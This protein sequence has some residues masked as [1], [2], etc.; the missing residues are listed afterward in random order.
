MTTFSTQNRDFSCFLVTKH[1]W[2]GKY[3]RVFSIGTHAITTYNPQTLEVTNQFL[4]DDFV[5]I[6]PTQRQPNADP[7]QGDEFVIVYRKK[8]KSDNMRFSS[9]FTQEILSQAL[10]FQSQFSE[11]PAANTRYS[12]VKYG[13][14]TEKQPCILEVGPDGLHQLDKT[15]LMLKVYRYNHIKHVYRLSDL[16]G[17]FV[18]E[19]GEQLRRHLFSNDD[20]N[21]LIQE[22]RANASECVGVYIPLAKDP[23]SFEDFV[24]TRLGL[25]SKDEQLTSYTEFKVQKYTPRSEKMP[26]RRLLCLSESCIIERDPATY[27]VICARPLK[28]IICLVREL[29]DPQKF[30]I[31]YENGD[32]RTYTSNERDLILASLIDGSRGSGNYNIFVASRRY[33]RN[34]RLM[35]FKQLLDEEGEAQLMKQIINVTPGLKRSD[36]IRRFNA[37]VPYN[38]LTYSTVSES[39]F[40]DSNKNRMIVN[41]LETVL[42]ETYAID[43]PESIQKTEAQLACLHRLF[44]SKSGF[45][46]FTAVNGVREKLGALV[47]GVLKRKHE[48]IDHATVEMLCSLMQ[49]MHANYELRLEQLNKQSLLSSKPFVEHLLDLIVEHVTRGTGALVIASMLD[50]LTYTV[51]YP[52]SET[53]GGD[54]F[55]VVIELVAERG[56][57]FYRLFHNPSMTIVKGAGMVMRAIIEESGREISKLMQT[58]S[59][60]E[61][62]FLKHLEMALLASGKDLRVLTNKQL[63]G[64]LISLWIA[65]NS[66]A[67][68]LLRRCIPRGLLDNLE[69]T[70][71]PPNLEKDLLLTRNNLEIATQETKSSALQ[72]QLKSMQYTV[73]AKLETFFQHWNLGQTMTKR[74][75]EKNQKPVVLRKR[76]RQVKTSANWKMFAY[77]FAQDHAK[78][79]LIWNEKTR[80]EFRQAIENEMRLLQQELEF[81]QKGDTLVSWNHTEF[82]IAYPSLQDEIKIGDYYLRFLLNEDSEAATPIHDPQ[83]F[84]NSVY[85]RFLLFTPIDMKCLCLKAMGIAYERHFMTIGAFVDSKYIVQML[86][87]CTNVA[88]RDHLL[89][90][91]NKL[92]LDKNN[93]RELITAGLLPILVDLAMLGHLHVNRP[94]LPTQQNVIEAGSTFTGS[95]SKEWHYTDKAGQRQGPLSFQEMKDLYKEGKIFEKTEIW[96]EGLD[97]WMNL[98]AVA[99]FRWTICCKTPANTNQPAG[100]YNLTQLTVLVLDTLIQ[101]C[102]F[103]PS[104][105][106][107]GA[108]IRPMP[109]V[110]KFLSDPV[111]LYQV[112]QLLLTYD[113]DVVRRVATLVL[114][115]M[116]DNP[117][118]S[119]LYLS[120]LYFFILMYNGSD[121]LPVAR[122]L[123]YTHLKQAFR[124]TLAKSEI[125]SCSV[126]SPILPEA[127]IYYLEQY[128]PEKYAEVFLGEFETPEIIWNTEMRRHMFEQIAKHVA[129]FSSRL[130]SNTKALYKY[131]PIPPI[132]YPQLEQELFCHYYYL[133]HLC[134]EI[135]FPNWEIRDPVVFLRCCLAAWHEELERKPPTMSIEKACETLGLDST[136]ESWQDGAAVRRAYY[137]LASQYHPDKNPEGGEIF[138][139]IYNAYEVLSSKLVREQNKTGTDVNR[140]AIILRTQ[141]IIYSRNLEELSPFKYAGYTQLI[142]TIDLEA[143]D[144]NLFSGDNSRSGKLLSAAVEL[145]YWTLRSS[146]LNAEQLRREAGLDALYKTFVRCVPM[147]SSGSNETDMPVQVC[148]HVCNCFATAGLF[149]ACRE[150]FCEMKEIFKSICH[151]LKFEHLSRLACAAAECVCS[152]SV[153]T[154]LQT[155]L[156]QAGII[157]HLMPHLFRF[158]YTLDEGGVQHNEDSNRQAVSNRLA[159]SSIEALACLAGFRETTPDNDGVQNSLRAMLTQFSCRLMASGENDRVLKILNS[160][161]EDPYIIWDN[162]TRAEL[163]DFV[164]RHRTSTENT[165]ELFGAEFKLSVYAKELIVGEIFV[166]IYNE[167]PEFKLDNAKKVCMDFLEFLKNR[168]DQL[169][170]VQPKANGQTAPKPMPRKKQPSDVLIDLDDDEDTP[171]P[172]NWGV[173]SSKSAANEIPLNEQVEMVWTALNNVLLHNPGIEFLLIGQ[174][175]LIF[176]Y[177]RLNHLPNV[178]LKTLGVIS[179]AANNKECVADISHSF[180]LPLLLILLVKFKESTEIILRT[181][182]A[183]VSNG[184]VVKALLEYGGLLYL[185]RI[186]SSTRDEETE[187]NRLLAAELLAKLQ[188]DKLTGPRWSRFIVRYLPPIFADSLRDSPSQAIQM[189]DSTTENPEL[190]WNDDIRQKVKQLV[191]QQIQELLIA[192]SRDATAKWNVGIQNTSNTGDEPTAYSTVIAGELIVGGVFIRLFN[193]NPTWTVRH[194]KQFATELMEAVLALMQKPNK[195]LE[196][197]TSALVSLIV[198]QPTTADQIPA[199]GYLPQFCRS[200]HNAN[201]ESS[202]AAL[203]IL[204]RLSENSFCANSLA[205]QPIIKGVQVCMQ[206]Q[207]GLISE[208]AHALKCL[209]KECGSDLAAQF[210]NTEIV[211]LLLKALSGDLAGTGNI[212]AAKAEIVDALKA[213][214]QDPVYGEKIGEILRNSPIWAQYKDQRHDLF[215][216]ASRTHAI[217]AGSASGQAAGYLTNGM[218][219]PPPAAAPPPPTKP[220][221]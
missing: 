99:Q 34:M 163:L 32:F 94:K 216:P 27:M 162:A 76:R 134:D 132:E 23:L 130:T 61:G 73:E 1:S 72:M 37:N 138:V 29:A 102:S 127:T 192:Q 96:A 79:D 69:S 144:S 70:E 118:I 15:G 119:R 209:T 42:A 121:I 179:K 7:K 221:S 164:E 110:K 147:V 154:L 151:L 65:E 103:F 187:T 58:L 181:L 200:M 19:V 153:S 199:Q 207:P 168:I 33:E 2:K 60:T 28:D 49:P 12:C 135:R 167:M 10:S 16:P 62:A 30:L 68:E 139:Q 67:M 175:P 133:R 173:Q 160:N 184:N 142:N 115:V 204:Q 170:G 43:D 75:Q 157:W 39:F 21:K 48:A 202:R 82:S 97:G 205:S 95:E 8:G 217:T 25:C 126:L 80:E 20:A 18:V 148:I 78:A 50:F 165:S 83:H 109:R 54:V 174:F 51:C 87:K 88:E 158:D 169:L 212:S 189:F 17:G 52:Y 84:F 74:E 194:P 129:D 11:R 91:I 104:R 186:L 146:A 113:P 4:Y 206:H 150:K 92:A 208:T 59:L 211:P 57:A 108:I 47:I 178:Q 35:P 136:N 191:G 90:V 100:L 190:I 112:V 22:F 145:C 3:R 183:L 31:E 38:G 14:S 117:Y 89:F 45:Q 140:I 156:F 107:S 137:K 116:Q 36:M 220:P 55:D 124:S 201:S 120:G 24:Q 46:A 141:S 71:K 182:I 56:R 81:M 152:F 5:S 143:D 86:S 197:V 64:Y 214:S 166:R 203:L 195:N 106:T 198:N 53:T 122:L 6:R 44:A 123:H 105:D 13:W 176:N 63:S 77:Q 114:D 128:G 85:H 180:Q 111:L 26:V 213:V 172:I 125:I 101:I 177:L 41:C 159:R 149:E 131:C 155:L 219:E 218:F 193:Q 196:S 93:V 161:I 215:L 188:A 9:E 210:V 40:S 98:S 66:A 185:L 171:P